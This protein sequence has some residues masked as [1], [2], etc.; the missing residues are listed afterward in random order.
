M[1]RIDLTR[2]RKSH[3]T[4]RRKPQVVELSPATYVMIEGT[5]DPSNT[6]EFEEKTQLLHN[7][8]G[9]IR[10]IGGSGDRNLAVPP[11]EA[12]W[13][14]ENPEDFSLQN[15]DLWKWTAM[16]MVPDFVTRDDFERA[17][18][19]LTHGRD[20]DALVALRL[21]TLQEGLCVQVL[22][23]GPYSE[24][25]ATLRLL[26]DFM[27]SRGY[28]TRGKH[29]EVYLGNPRKVAPEKLR[30]IVRRPVEPASG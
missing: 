11:L 28:R 1:R 18:E 21:G 27:E 25:G 9:R 7:L 22:H 19:S 3:F 16:L 8:V 12:L 2:Q 17:R 5:G 23:V 6:R 20:D 10:T 30:T 26:N 24:E 13:W 29:H 4:A 15:R 14:T